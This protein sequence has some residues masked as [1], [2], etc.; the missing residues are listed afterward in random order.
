MATVRASVRNLVGKEEKKEAAASPI[1][2]KTFRLALAASAT[3]LEGESGGPGGAI[4]LTPSDME[5]PLVESD[6][7]C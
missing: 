4:R 3:M 2:A 1:D 5:K 6:P 7:F